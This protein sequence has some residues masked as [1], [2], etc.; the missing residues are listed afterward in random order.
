[1]AS[2][3]RI[4]VGSAVTDAFSLFSEGSPRFVALAQA[5]MI[6]GKAMSAAR[7]VELQE[8]GHFGIV[9]FGCMVMIS[10]V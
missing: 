1:V 6:K 3:I 8:G 2:A 10:Q 7:A 9:G 4:S 5:P